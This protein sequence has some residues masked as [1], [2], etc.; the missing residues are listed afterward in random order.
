MEINF[1]L[2]FNEL[3]RNI[4]IRNFRYDQ[5]LYYNLHMNIVFVMK[6]IF[7]NNSVAYP[8][9]D[10]TFSFRFETFDENFAVKK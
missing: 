2:E 1:H 3:M 10:Q 6:T 9:L 7:Q 4:E 8:G 5:I